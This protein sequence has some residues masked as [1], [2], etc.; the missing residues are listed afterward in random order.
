MSDFDWDNLDIDEVKEIIAA[1][2]IEISR[3]KKDLFFANASIAKRESWLAK[4]K[5]EAGYHPNISFDAVWSD[6]LNLAKRFKATK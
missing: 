6:T 4:A 3:L 2:A 5:A 1:N